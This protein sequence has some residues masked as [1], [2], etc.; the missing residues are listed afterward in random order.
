MLTKQSLFA[1]LSFAAAVTAQLQIDKATGLGFQPPKRTRP[2]ACN[3]PNV[4]APVGASAPKASAPKDPSIDYPTMM[5]KNHPFDRSNPSGA[6]TE[7]CWGSPNGP[8]PDL[9]CIKDTS[10]GSGKY[11]AKLFTEETL[12]GKTIYAPASPPTGGEKMPLVVWGN[13]A[14]LEEGMMFYNFLIEIASHGFFVVANGN[15]NGGA[16]AASG[17]AASSPAAGGLLGG[18]MSMGR[19]VGLIQSID[20]AGNHTDILKKYG[21]VDLERIIAAGQSCGTMQSVCHPLCFILSV[22]MIEVEC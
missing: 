16:A 19:G 12:A 17:P 8:T 14:C 4:S 10:G 3:S 22:A 21:N 7:D 5:C 13:G 6:A 20:W 15:P 2:A 9:A 1:I 18:A 11:K